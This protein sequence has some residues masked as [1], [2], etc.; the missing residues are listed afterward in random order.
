MLPCVRQH[1]IPIALSACG[2]RIVMPSNDLRDS[3]NG[4]IVSIGQCSWHVGFP[5]LRT[6]RCVAAKGRDAHRGFG[7]NDQT[8]DPATQAPLWLRASLADLKGLDFEAPTVD[9]KTGDSC[10]LSPLY[11]A[12]A[13]TAGE[14]GTLPDTP[15]G[16]GARACKPAAFHRECDQHI[17]QISRAFA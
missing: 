14:D 10:D 5:R 12:A 16:A 4:S 2:V 9:A 17:A 11:R 6:Y 15:T 3:R 1:E 13:G 7:M 8:P